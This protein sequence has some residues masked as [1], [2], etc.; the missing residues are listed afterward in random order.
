MRKREEID[1]TVEREKTKKEKG[2]KERG[3]RL[4]KERGVRERENE[5]PGLMKI[6]EKV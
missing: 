6:M 4:E 1:N 3:N 5:K 2:E